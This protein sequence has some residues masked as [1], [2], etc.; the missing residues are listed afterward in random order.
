MNAARGLNPYVRPGTE[1]A[2]MMEEEIDA[3]VAKNPSLLNKYST[4]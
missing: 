2:K 1:T 3:L 4:F